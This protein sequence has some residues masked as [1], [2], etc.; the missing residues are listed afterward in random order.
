[1]TDRASAPRLMRAA[2]M[3][4][5]AFHFVVRAYRSLQFSRQRGEICQRGTV[6]LP[7]DVLGHKGKGT[8]A[9]VGRTGLGPSLWGFLP[10]L[11]TG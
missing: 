10:Y 6:G 4:A 3:M 5:S 11:T 2:T 7:V 9:P 1:M 8:P